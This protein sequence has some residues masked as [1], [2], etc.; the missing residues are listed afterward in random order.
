MSFGRPNQNGDVDMSLEDE[1][2]GALDMEMVSDFPHRA[3][4][5]SNGNHFSA[6]LVPG[7]SN[8][9]AETPGN[10]QS[11][12]EYAALMG[13]TLDTNN[14]H[15]NTNE[16]SASY[17]SQSAEHQPSSS[18]LAKIQANAQYLES[19]CRP[20]D[21]LSSNNATS[22][23]LPAGIGSG[24]G[25]ASSNLF[26]NSNPSTSTYGQSS[27]VEYAPAGLNGGGGLYNPNQPSVVPSSGLFSLQHSNDNKIAHLGLAGSVPGVLPTSHPNSS[28]MNGL[29]APTQP[30][31]PVNN[32]HQRWLHQHELGS[33]TL[34]PEVLNAMLKNNVHAHQRYAVMKEEEKAALLK[35]EKSRERNRD[36]SRKS[37]LRKKEF[38]EN[39][40][41]E[42][43][44]LHIY[45]ELCEQCSD[46]IAMLS[47][48]MPGYIFAYRSTAHARL[49]GYEMESIVIGQS[50]F[51]DFVHSGDLSDVKRHFEALSGPRDFT[52]FTFRIKM[53]NG[54]Y[55]RAE[56]SARPIGINME[57]PSVRIL[58]VGDSG[59]GKTTLLRKLCNASEDVKVHAHRWT[60]GCDQ[61][62]LIH[63]HRNQHGQH[64]TYFVEF[65]DV[66]G[67]PTYK[68]SIILVQ[69]LSNTKSYRHLR[70]WL[71]YVKLSISV[72]VIVQCCSEIALEHQKNGT[73]VAT[74]TFEYASHKSLFAAVPKL[75]LANKRDRIGAPSNRAVICTDLP[76]ETLESTAIPSLSIDLHAFSQYLDRVIEFSNDV[77]SYKPKAVSIDRKSTSPH[78]IAQNQTLLRRPTKGSKTS[79]W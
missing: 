78:L 56:T 50:S 43:Q 13:I 52:I 40:K 2:L 10:F 68:Q 39:L 23:T 74:N 41:H 77:A 59:A 70:E 32:P 19:L 35:E 16:H 57:I 24:L 60:T 21:T 46:L 28:A 47:T 45:Q 51:L 64:L 61:H 9:S 11:V 31:G 14:V 55:L 53:A 20:R 15:P 26:G 36:H 62:V 18:E 72:Y 6:S 29:L 25:G 30:F 67:H 71:R 34:S 3:N 5:S 76:Q 75:I 38:V 1:D 17:Y 66:S 63:T 73:V 42:V 33:Q 54:S 79:W 65:V 4:L 49:L 12:E 69:D 7:V 58:V 44:Q 22:M 48:E 27:T 37:R 8:S